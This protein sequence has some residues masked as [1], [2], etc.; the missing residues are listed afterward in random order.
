MLVHHTVYKYSGCI[1]VWRALK[2]QPNQKSQFIYYFK[3]KF[4]RKHFPPSMQHYILVIL[5]M[6]SLQHW[7]NI[8]PTLLCNIVVMLENNVEEMSVTYIEL[9][10]GCRWLLYFWW[11]YICLYLEVCNKQILL[12]VWHYHWNVF[13]AFSSKDWMGFLSPQSPELYH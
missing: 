7:R 12:S 6:V 1:R 11:C 8:T 3:L 4:K 5:A 9:P 13:L 2:R 10:S